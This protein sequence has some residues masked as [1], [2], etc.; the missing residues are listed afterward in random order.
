MQYEHRPCWCKPLAQ[1]RHS[2][3]LTPISAQGGQATFKQPKPRPDALRIEFADPTRPYAVSR[4]HLSAGSD[5]DN[6][7]AASLMQTRWGW[8]ANSVDSEQRARRARQ[9]NNRPSNACSAFCRPHG[10]FNHLC[11][12]HSRCA[13]YA[14][15]TRRLRSAAKPFVRLEGHH[16][17]RPGQRQVLRTVP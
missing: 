16:C 3:P 13:L 9:E 4:A 1:R 7:L 11:A 17:E 8:S 6:G 15:L 5:F 2:G 14:E 12:A 10:I